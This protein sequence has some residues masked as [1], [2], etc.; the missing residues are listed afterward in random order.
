[1]KT[2]RNLILFFVVIGV[3]VFLYC[4]YNSDKCAGVERN[5]RLKFNG[6]V[7]SIYIT[8]VTHVKIYNGTDTIEPSQSY[9]KVLLSNIQIGDSLVKFPY[10]DSCIIY[11]GLNNF[12][13]PLNYSNCPCE[14]SDK[15]KRQI[16]AEFK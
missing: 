11:K 8:R 2:K 15:I 7:V 6:V 16:D 14:E 10:S 9:S 1:M 4:K 12:M 13:V 3:F 5:Y